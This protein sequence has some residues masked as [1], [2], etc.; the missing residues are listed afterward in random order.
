[1]KNKGQRTESVGN[2]NYAS[3]QEKVLMDAV[4]PSK[5]KKEFS[6]IHYAFLVK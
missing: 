6:E 3:H 1:M 4:G 5:F 2:P